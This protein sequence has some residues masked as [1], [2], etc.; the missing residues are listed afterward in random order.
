MFRT[1]ALPRKWSTRWMWSSGTSAASVLFRW[2]ADCSSEP[3]GFSMT[4]RV[5]AGTSSGARASHASWLTRGGRA[6]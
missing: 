3:N 2:R 1:V 5:P 6:K 4:S